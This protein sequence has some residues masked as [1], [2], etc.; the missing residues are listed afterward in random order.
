MIYHETFDT[1][2][3]A[4]KAEYAFKHHSHRLDSLYNG[5]WDGGETAFNYTSC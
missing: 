3:E 5:I 1:K 4:L 2:S